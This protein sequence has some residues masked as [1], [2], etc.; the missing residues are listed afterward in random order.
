MGGA[1]AG[2]VFAGI[3][4]DLINCH[5]KISQRNFKLEQKMGM[6]IIDFTQ[7]FLL[8]FTICKTRETV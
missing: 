7:N 4:G 1:L 8:S 5:R 3:F 2:S 6:K